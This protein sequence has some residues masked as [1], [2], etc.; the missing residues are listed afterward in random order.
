MK[1]RYIALLLGLLL[2]LTAC[3]ESAAPVSAEPAPEPET[4]GAAEIGSAPEQAA[5]TTDL[6]ASAAG[7]PEATPEPETG[8][9]TEGHTEGSTEGPVEAEN[10]DGQA[11]LS[12]ILSEYQ[13]G[14][15]YD[16]LSAGYFWRAVGYLAGHGG[17]T[18]EDGRVTLTEEQLDALVIALFGPYE[19]Q[20]P[21]LSEEDPF[22]TEEYVDG[23]TVY[24]VITTGPF[25]YTAN[26]GQPEPQGDGTYRCRVELLRDGAVQTAYTV[27]LADYPE[28]VS[29]AF[30]Y[31]ITGL[32]PA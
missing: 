19:E 32:E 2:A 26:K 12:A 8:S 13:D 10:L 18:V 29:G 20:Y 31:C 1:Y 30:T 14:Y 6:P 24:T 17:G 21:S 7:A 23:Q 4:F 11:L 5:E 22:V 27:T 3:G 9:F 16:P 28:G 15:A 25:H